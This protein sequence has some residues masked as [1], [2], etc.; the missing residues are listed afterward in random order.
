MDDKYEYQY[1][2]I[3]VKENKE[4]REPELDSFVLPYYDLGFEYVEGYRNFD[5]FSTGT[6]S[7]TISSMGEV[8][9]SKDYR[10]DEYYGIVLR[11][12]TTMKNYKQL[13]D[14]TDE[15]SDY[16]KSMYE[17]KSE[18]KWYDGIVFL[19]LIACF[20]YLAVQFMK[21]GIL[22]RD[23]GSILFEW[24]DYALFGVSTFLVGLF[25][26]LFIKVRFI[27]GGRFAVL[28]YKKFISEIRKEGRKLL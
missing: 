24:L 5:L 23:S 17:I 26:F 4:I 9:F 15:L 19:I 20:T 21:S 13:K 2:R 6:Y 1:I 16:R 7:G 28:K 18:Q 8:H 10:R 12:D 3:Y 25:T 14:L 22:N 11:R 27:A